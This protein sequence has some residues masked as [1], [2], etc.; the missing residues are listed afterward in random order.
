M[1]VHVHVGA[2]ENG[3][4][5]G[6]KVEAPNA[7]AYGDHSPTTIGLTGNKAIALYQNREAYVFDYEVVYANTQQQEHIVDMALPRAFM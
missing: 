3:I 6:I 2:D 1:E 7:G 4:V 5:K